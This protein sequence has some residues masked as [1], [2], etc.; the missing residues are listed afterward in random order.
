MIFDRWDK[1][2]CEAAVIENESER[3]IYCPFK[4]C[5]ALMIVDDDTP[6]ESKCPSCNRQI[7]VTCGEVW[8]HGS[9]CEENEDRVVMEVVARNRW[10]RCPNCSVDQNPYL[11]C[12]SGECKV[13]KKKRKTKP[14]LV[15]AAI[16]ISVVLVALT[17]AAVV[18]TLKRRKTKVEMTPKEIKQDDDVSLKFKNKIYSYSDILKIT[19][20]FCQILGKG[21]F[22]TVYMGYVDDAPVAVKMLSQ[23]SVQ[24]YQQFQAE[25]LI[26]YGCVVKYVGSKLDDN[27]I[28]IQCPVPRC[29]GFLELYGCREVLPKI[30][31]DRWDKLLC[32]AAVVENE[33]ERF[34]YCPF[35]DCSALMIVNDDS[36]TESECSNCNRHICVT[37]GEVWHHEITC[38]ENEDRVVMEVA[39]K[40]RWKRCQTAG[41][42]LRKDVSAAIKS[43]AGAD[44]CSVIAVEIVWVLRPSVSVITSPPYSVP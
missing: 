30:L 37:C 19:N 11:L 6:T 14:F 44:I 22:G 40:N 16:G 13:K 18:W 33:S 15:A 42:L 3:F 43:F 41:S 20:N 26:L 32:E 4:D 23:S 27:V 17:A 24:G 12:E 25:P 31:F 36:P 2:L 35:K 8:H 7:C 28:N 29:G 5:S 9:T 34:M 10:K 39:A 21:G 38:E 1:L